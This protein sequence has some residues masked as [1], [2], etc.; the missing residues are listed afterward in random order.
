MHSC[1]C[2]PS[3]CSH[4]GH[5][6]GQSW[7]GGV[8]WDRDM[9]IMQAIGDSVGQCPA[10]FLLPAG[11]LVAGGIDFAVQKYLMTKPW[12]GSEVEDVP[13]APHD[14]PIKEKPGGNGFVSAGFIR[15]TYIAAGATG[16]AAALAVD[17]SGGGALISGLAATLSSTMVVYG[18]SLASRNSSVYDPYW[19][20]LPQGLSVYSPF[21]SFPKTPNHSLTHRATHI[22]PPSVYSS[23]SYRTEPGP[24]RRPRVPLALLQ[25]RSLHLD[26][27]DIQPSKLFCFLAVWSCRSGGLREIPPAQCSLPRPYRCASCG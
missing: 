11:I 26:S 25:T 27:C 12:S 21:P 5:G 20:L 16:W 24:S 8:G 17:R 13:S 1:C 23:L 14:S 2:A 3:Q 6:T 19:C 15:S 10:H 7:A 9:G 22:S 4:A 18:G